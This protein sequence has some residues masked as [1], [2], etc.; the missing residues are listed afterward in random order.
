MYIIHVGTRLV[1]LLMW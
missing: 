1:P